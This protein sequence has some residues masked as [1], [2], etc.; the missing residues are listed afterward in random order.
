MTRYLI[1][2]AAIT[3]TA[4]LFTWQHA[5]QPTAAVDDSSAHTLQQWQQI[6]PD[7]VKEI[8]IRHDSAMV[9]LN[10]QGDSWMVA[11][12]YGS[13]EADKS[14]VTQLLKSI[15]EM[16]PQR[17]V[18]SNPQN[19]ALFRVTDS[20]DRLTLKGSSGALLLD[21]LV[22]KPGTDLISTTIRPVGSNSIISVN[23]SLAW[24]MGRSPDSW[25]REKRGSSGS[26]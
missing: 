20:A 22:G 9:H 11:D 23:R 14:S 25:R 12:R 13:V 6:D 15:S 19:F 17:V 7:Q 24:Q 10:R 2:L 21:I 4:A 3:I 26:S 18:S 5:S 8:N 16:R 1:T